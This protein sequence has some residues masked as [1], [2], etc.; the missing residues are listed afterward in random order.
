MLADLGARTARAARRHDAQ[1]RHVPSS[2]PASRC[3]A[4]CLWQTSAEA[5]LPK[6]ALGGWWL[7]GSTDTSRGIVLTR[8]DLRRSSHSS[9]ASHLH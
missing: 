1:T 8:A 9:G 7:G 5:E 6:K 4:L 3:L 2:P